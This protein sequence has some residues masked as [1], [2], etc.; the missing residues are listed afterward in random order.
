MLEYLAQ[1]LHGCEGMKSL[2]LTGVGNNFPVKLG[3]SIATMTSLES[4]ELE[5]IELT[6]VVCQSVLRGL[7]VLSQLKSLIIFRIVLTDCLGY[8]FNESNH[9]GFPCLETLEITDVKLSTDDLTSLANA[10]ST[11]KLPQL[12]YL[13]MSK[14]VLA[15]K[16]GILMGSQRGKYVVYPAL[17]ML[18]FARCA[19]NQVDVRSI[20]QA[21]TRNQFPELQY[22]NLRSNTLTDCIIDLFGEEIDPSFSSP[23]E[24]NFSCT[25]LSATDLRNLSRAFS[26][27]VMSNCKILDLSK[28][29]LT[30]IV[31]EL[32]TENGLPFVSFLKLQNTQ[33]SARDRETFADA[34]KASKLP[35][36]T[37]LYL[38]DRKFSM[39]EEQVK[40]LL[41]ACLAAYT[42]HSVWVHVTLDGSS[43]Y[44]EI[45]E[46][47]YERCKGTNFILSIEPMDR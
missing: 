9:H 41:E 12:K 19:L 1:E 17:Q 39:T 35:A 4:V 27:R 36:L 30:G 15:D 14:N 21:L 3:E 37:R 25:K 23:K 32:F 29:K 20:S 45:K 16:V 38:E 5:R 7:S 10:V 43:D 47:L 28:N 2:L 33:L 6:S 11:G 40:Q 26:H 31:A 13:L 22:L 24:L 8:L 34:I 44:E 42:T 18:S 46:R